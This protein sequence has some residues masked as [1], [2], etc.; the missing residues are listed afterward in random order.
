MSCLVIGPNLELR[1]LHTPDAEE[2][3][4]L[5]EAN[6]AYLR[7]W[8]PWLDGTR[9]VSDS[10]SFIVSAMRQFAETRAFVAG[11]RWEGKLAGVIGHNRIDWVE[12]TSSFG[13]WLGN[14]FQGKGIMTS[15]CRTLIGHAFSELKLERVVITCATG[16][17][18]SRAI[19]ERLGFRCEGIEPQAEWLY[20]HFVD[21]AVYSLTPETFARLGER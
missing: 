4:R 6:R 3:F 7:Q 9:T 13:Y 20:D 5:T 12:G 11:I 18:R 15:C 8:L 16:N 19:P 14:D 21:H 10:R 1:L 17:T 2:L